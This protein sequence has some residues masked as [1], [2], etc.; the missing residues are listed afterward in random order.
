M[1]LSAPSQW[2]ANE[3]TLLL[4]APN[5]SAAPHDVTN[6]QQLPDSDAFS[7]VF[8]RVFVRHARGLVG[9][10][11]V[12]REELK[13]AL[14]ALQKWWSPTQCRYADCESLHRRIDGFHVRHS[15]VPRVSRIAAPE[16]GVKVLF[17]LPESAEAQVLTLEA[18][19]VSALRFD[20]GAG[21]TL[22]PQRRQ[23]AGEYPAYQ[24]AH[25]RRRSVLAANGSIVS[26][27]RPLRH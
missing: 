15:C 18:W 11:E 16:M 22:R 24:D 2:L 27:H 26:V 3:L 21:L 17:T 12:D 23:A 25:A 9:G 7:A 19:C 10:R 6:A 5:H 20:S 1:S 8:N 13:Q 4:S 14:R